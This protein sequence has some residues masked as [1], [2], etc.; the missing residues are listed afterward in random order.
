MREIQIITKQWR[1]SNTI[2]YTFD[3]SFIYITRVLHNL[4]ILSFFKAKLLPAFINQVAFLFSRT[5]PAVHRPL[6][7]L[8][9]PLTSH[10]IAAASQYQGRA[11]PAVARQGVAMHMKSQGKLEYV[12]PG[13]FPKQDLTCQPVLPILVLSK[14]SWEFFHWLEVRKTLLSYLWCW[15]L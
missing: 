3:N 2:C 9:Q 13:N 14:I 12:A 11:C 8:K 10:T 1:T 4:L 6:S 15:W 5:F 7:P